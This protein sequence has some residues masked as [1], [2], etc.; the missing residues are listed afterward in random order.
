[1][2]KKIAEIIKKKQQQAIEAHMPAKNAPVLS[3]D[4]MDD[5]DLFVKAYDEAWIDTRD[6]SRNIETDGFHA[7]S[8]GISHGKC[9]RRNVYLLRGVAKRGHFPPRILRVFENGH[10]VH[11]RTQGIMESM[12]IGMRSEVPVVLDE[13]P[14]KGHADGVFTWKGREILLEIK[15][16]S[17]AVF[18]NRL[19]WK[20]P[21][22]EHF[23][24]A[25]IYAYVLGLDVIWFLYENKDNQEV[26]IFERKADPV[27]AK[28]QID[29]WM[30]QWRCF[31]ADETPKRPYKPGS[32]TCGGC[33]VREYC[34]A[35]S[36]VGVDVKKY[37]EEDNDGVG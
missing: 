23:D 37:K 13:P 25:N 10:G 14:I 36:E 3:E 17:D 34:F 22:D 24:Q 4:E 28:K 9:A 6:T 27:K 16:C 11:S 15:S 5:I 31:K 7:S 2:S 19:K 33:D 30:M 21:K 20:K 12:G 32:S 8:L 29:A 35:D 18:V 1:M 26:K